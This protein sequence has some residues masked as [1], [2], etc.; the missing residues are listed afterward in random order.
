MLGFGAFKHPRGSGSD[1]GESGRV[2]FHER[3]FWVMRSSGAI[4]G[5]LTIQMNFGI[6]PRG[7]INGP[8][9]ELSA[10]SALRALHQERLNTWRWKRTGKPGA[11]PFPS[12]LL[13]L[14]ELWLLDFTASSHCLMGGRHPR[15]V[16]AIYQ[17]TGQSVGVLLC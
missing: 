4:S 2:E 16:T 3:P 5:P 12:V 13:L 10:N 14:R 8:S 11:A 9:S 15:H 7:L 17:L 1:H 6:R